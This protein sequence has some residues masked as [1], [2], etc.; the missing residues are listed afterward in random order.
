MNQLASAYPLAA[1]WV[2]LAAFQLAV[3]LQRKTGILALQPVLV[4]TALVVAA[5]YV[6][7]VDYAAYRDANTVLAALLGPTTVA[8]AVPLCQN[9]ARV[10]QLF[11]PLMITLIAGGSLGI[12]LTL[13]FGWLLGLR[14]ELMM[15]LVPKSVTMP[16]ALPLA[17]SLGG[18]APL[19]AVIVM[20]T[21]VIGTAL[22]PPLLHRLGVVDPAARGFTLG[23]N[24]HAIGTAHA[25][26]ESQECAAFSALGMILL[27][28]ATAILLPYVLS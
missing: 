7:D 15:S 17:D 10:R 24:A 6:F 4:T 27:G 23:M 9:L 19:A 25:L 18:I 26:Q 11:G 12:V 20:F 28:L 8:L 2:T 21:G 16:I 5:L 22:A 13:L 14:P 1:L 3:V